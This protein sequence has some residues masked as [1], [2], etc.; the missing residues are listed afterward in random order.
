MFNKKFYSA[1]K[2]DFQRF[3]KAVKQAA[4]SLYESQKILAVMYSKTGNKDVMTLLKTMSKSNEYL[5]LI[6]ALTSPE[7]NK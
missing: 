3:S 1:N 4:T 5:D 7:F 2:S 6:S